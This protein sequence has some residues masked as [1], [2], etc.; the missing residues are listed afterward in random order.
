MMERSELFA[1]RP[2]Q[3]AGDGCVLAL[4]MSTISG[5]HTLKFDGV[6]DYAEIADDPSLKPSELTVEVWAYP[7]KETAPG[8]YMHVVS[9]MSK[10]P[11]AGWALCFERDREILFAWRDGTTTYFAR[12]GSGYYS[13]NTWYH[14][15][16]TFK[17]NVGILYINTR[18][19]QQTTGGALSHSPGTLQIGNCVAYAVPFDGL[20]GEVRLYSRVLNVAEIEHNM[21]H[22]NDPVTDGLVLWVPF[23]EGSGTAVADKSGKGNDGTIYGAIWEKQ[24]LEDLSGYGNDATHYGPVEIVGKY[25]RALSFDGIDD[26]VDVPHSSSINLSDVITIE[27]W[28]KLDRTDTFNA[29]IC[30]GSG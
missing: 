25:L 20:I 5:L 6:D 9:K 8:E 4:D 15:V 19:I 22:R 10:T 24:K 29:A 3:I 30:K 27:I 14:V 28:A 11:Y 23:D 16:A 13:A 7:Y 2:D 12:T 17:D 1:I 18:L 21:L 26:Y